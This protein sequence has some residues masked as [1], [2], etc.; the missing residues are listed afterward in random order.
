MGCYPT[1]RDWLTARTSSAEKSSGTMFAAGLLSG[2]IGYVLAC[3][4]SDWCRSGA[5]NSMFLEPWCAVVASAELCCTCETLGALGR[6]RPAGCGAG[7]RH[8]RCPHLTSDV[9]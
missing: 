5:W 2:G 9:L 7:G 3:L 4:D 1:V 6:P 8:A